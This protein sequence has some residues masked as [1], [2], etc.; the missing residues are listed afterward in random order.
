MIGSILTGCTRR[1]I[2]LHLFI[3]LFDVPRAFC[4]SVHG[5]HSNNQD[6]LCVSP[7]LPNQ[8]CTGSKIII[9]HEIHQHQTYS[10]H[11][12]TNITSSSN[13]SSTNRYR[14]QNTS[15][16]PSPL[17]SRAKMAAALTLS[18]TPHAHHTRR[19]ST[20]E[21]S[22]PLAIADTLP[23][24]DFGFEALKTRMTQ[25]TARFDEFIEKGRK[26]VL[27]ERN[28]FKASVAELEGTYNSNGVL[29]RMGAHDGC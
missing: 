15:H 17:T 18:S 4:T 21:K 3:V 11:V 28:G 27:E 12:A 5:C 22:S 25:F 26:R 6:S 2:Q 29:V 23:S 1:D 8:A 13:S 20:H 14:H 10:S 16:L 9:N 19:T 7:T 24:V